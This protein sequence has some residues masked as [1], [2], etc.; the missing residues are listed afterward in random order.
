MSTI[1]DEIK[2]IIPVLQ[3]I[4]SGDPVRTGERQCIERTIALLERAARL[5]AETDEENYLEQENCIFRL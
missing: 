2:S 1:S 4:S 3:G 5:E